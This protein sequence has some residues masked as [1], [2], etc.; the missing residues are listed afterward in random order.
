M[1]LNVDEIKQ[2]YRYTAL[3]DKLAEIRD[4][5]SAATIAQGP[6]ALSDAL[7]HIDRIA[8]DA[9]RELNAIRDYRPMESA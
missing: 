5:V 3:A 6:H 7:R 4:S 9:Q 8:Y 2:Q 1:T